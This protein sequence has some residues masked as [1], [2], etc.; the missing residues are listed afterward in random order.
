MKIF[1]CKGE[2]ATCTKRDY[3]KGSCM[4]CA[5]HQTLFGDEIKKTEMG[6]TYGTVA[7]KK[8]YSQSF[9]GET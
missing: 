7:G 2:E 9:G 4:V 8:M 1:C 5:A 3:I 6:G